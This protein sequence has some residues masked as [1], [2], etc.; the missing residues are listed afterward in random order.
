MEIYMMVNGLMELN[1]EEV[2]IINPT[3][4]HIIAENGKMEKEMDMEF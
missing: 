1:V 4:V 2:F 3:Q